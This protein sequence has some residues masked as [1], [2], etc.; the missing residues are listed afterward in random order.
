MKHLIFSAIVLMLFSCKKTELE[1]KAPPS[2]PKTASR[3]VDGNKSLLFGSGSYIKV[4]VPSALRLT[5]FTLE[6]WVMPT[7]MGNTSQSGD[8]GVRGMPIITKGRG[9]GDYPSSLNV[10]YF[11][12]INNN[13]KLVADFEED[14]GRNHPIT[15][16]VI[17]PDNNW[18]HVAVSYEPESAV[19]KVYI[20]GKLNTTKDL[21][22]NITPADASVAATA[23]ATSMNSRRN[24]TR[25]L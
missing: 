20:D 16:N 1:Q 8:G 13:K 21:G 12:A 22:S 14:N 11:L 19:W 23:I 18:T 7:G 2:S 3:T 9:E 5:T 17:I 24:C 10:N 4:D 15:S 6:A 25:L